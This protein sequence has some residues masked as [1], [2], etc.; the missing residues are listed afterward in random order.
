VNGGSGVVESAG[1]AA[2]DPD[3]PLEPGSASD[4]YNN[5]ASDKYISLQRAR[6]CARVTI[7]FEFPQQG[8]SSATNYYTP[9]QSVGADGV[10]NLS[11]KM[12]LALFPPGESFFRLQLSGKAKQAV[13]DEAED[14]SD[15]HSKFEGVLSKIEQ[16][17][18]QELEAKGAR[19]AQTHAV[20]QLLIAGNICVQ[21]NPDNS[22]I[23]HRLENYVVRRDVDGHPV[24]VIVRQT[25]KRA[26]LPPEAARMVAYL[27]KASKKEAAATSAVS[28]DMAA[29]DRA[30]TFDGGAIDLFLACEVELDEE[31]E[32][33]RWKFWQE[34]MGHKVPGSEGTWPLEAPAIIPICWY[35]I[36]GEHYG[37]S[38]VEEYLGD[39]NSLEALTQTYI[40][41][42]GIAGQVKFGVDETGITSAED[43]MNTANGGTFN[44]AVADGKLKDVG[45]FQVQK[46][47]DIEGSMNVAKI[48]TDRLNVAFMK[49]DSAV[50]DSERTTAEEI[51]MLAK[52]LE[53]RLGG[54]YA[55]LSQEF[56]RPLVVRVLLNL[57]KQKRIPAFPRGMVMPTVIA[58]LEGLGREAALQKLETA[59]GFIQ[60]IG[61]QLL[62][63]YLNSG[64]II[65]MVFSSLGLDAT[66]VVKS[67]D[68]VA[69]EAQAQQ[70]H[71]LKVAT[72]GH[73][74]KAASD[75][76]K[77][78]REHPDS[79]VDSA[80]G[81]APGGMSFSGGAAQAPP[82]P[83]VR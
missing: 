69:Q 38:F 55:S 82:Q 51:R 75:Q 79:P 56:Q 29:A 40:E 76:A 80:G 28:T 11:A 44:A 12:V 15:T 45:V 22:L 17:I 68:Q 72:A 52:A 71:E 67:D 58:G 10:N 42:A 36:Q 34:L 83:A 25:L 24:E 37:R 18:V 14:P 43:I 50:R 78:Q 9:F 4:R 30:T 54:A 26:S 61:P 7:P 33:Q 1:G 19:I 3:T 64:P 53:D 48:L 46:N 8:H 74:I 57:Q 2:W 31:H 70:D 65:R 59:V 62:Q 5:L 27:E 39:L 47:A 16:E 23:A 20:R 41:Y 21:V 32:P 73:I 63:Q 77:S 66:G 35:R 6:Q 49:A 13:E 81:G 60:K